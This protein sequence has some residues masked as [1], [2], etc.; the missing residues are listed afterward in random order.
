MTLVRDGSR[1]PAPAGDLLADSIARALEADIIFG[2]LSPGRKLGEEQLAERFSASRHQVREA[3]ARLQR[4]G[5]VT[6]QR[7][8]S[9]SVRSFSAAEVEQIYDVR[10]MIQRQAALRIAL[11]A[12][13][14]QIATMEAIEA[15][16]EHA[17]AQGDLRRICE[18]NDRFHLALFGLC[19]NEML[20]Q[21]VKQYM[22]LS[23]VIRANAFNPEHLAV[24]RREHRMMLGLLAGRDSWSL[25][26][27]CIDHIQHS[28]VQY[29]AFLRLREEGGA[30]SMAGAPR[31][32]PLHPAEA[33]S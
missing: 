13:R 31:S 22:D 4:M 16:Y 17:V 33:A 1:P 24:A 28:K 3:L 27:L 5:I 15:D 26:Q 12:G 8:K 18:A 21:L 30:G 6:K 10:E 19:G 14:L 20:V 23:Y 32:W 2:R 25:A 11:P 29:L 7:N 9:V